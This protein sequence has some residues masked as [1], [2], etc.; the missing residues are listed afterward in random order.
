MNARKIAFAPVY[1][2]LTAVLL[3]TAFLAPAS[4]AVSIAVTNFRGAW[5]ATVNYGAGAFVTY[6]GQSY[7]AVVKNNNVV[8]TDTDAWSILDAAGAQGPQ[9]PQGPVGPN[10]ASGAK[11]AAGP[12]GPAGPAGPIGLPGPVGPAGA[13]GPAGTAGANGTTGASGTP[14]APGV[15]GP[16]G[17]P[18]A[19][20]VG[21][22]ATC[23]AGDVAVV[24]QG[25]WACSPSGLPRFVANGD[26]TVTDNLTGLIWE[27]QTTA[28]S[29]VNCVFNQYTWSSSGTLADGTLFT[30]FL[31]TLN[32]GDYNN[33]ATAQDVT[34]GAGTCFANH[35]DWRIPTISE[36]QTLI[37]TAVPGCGSTAPCIDP[38]FGPTSPLSQSAYWSISTTST[39]AGSAYFSYLLDGAAQIVNKTFSTFARAVR[40]GR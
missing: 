14:G 19:P 2:T 30:N 28:C 25:A 31:A 18:G 6:R 36:L 20:G 4:A 35:C 38:V 9:G 33:A 29:A 1:T 5:D 12:T 13:Q 3:S 27:M 24:Y 15:P 10:G 26:S 23:Q 32:G 21:L 37:E 7:I 39:G 11:G 8:P 17:T 34:T 22:P 16:A 40:S